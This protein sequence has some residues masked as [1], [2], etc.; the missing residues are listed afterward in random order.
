MQ[1]QWTPTSWQDKTAQ[2]QANYPDR[3]KLDKVVSELSELPPLV[4]S[5]EIDRLRTEIAEAQEGKRFILQGGDCAESL[6]ECNSDKIAKQLKILLQMNLILRYGM[7]IP[8]T[9]IGRLAGQYAKPRSAD[10]ETRDGITLPSYRGDLINQ[11]PFTE[12]ARIP[13]PKFLLK[14]YQYAGLTINFVRS[15]IDGGFSE[16][17]HADDWDLDFAEHSPQAEEFHNIVK[18]ILDSIG[19]FETF[20]HESGQRGRNQTIYTSH[21]GLH[22]HYEQAQTRFLP[23]RNDWYNLSTHLP[24]IGARTA[25]VEHAHV[26]YFSGIR[27]PIG[28]KVGPAM[29]RD[30]LDALIDKLNP[31]NEAGRLVLIHR[32]GADKIE[33]H[34][35]KLINIV[36][37]KQAKVLW[38]CDPMHGNT[39]TTDQ[40][41]K[42]RHFDNIAKEVELAFK[43]HKENGSRLG[44]VHFELTGENVTE[45]IGGARGLSAA[46]LARAYKTQVDPRLNYEQ[47]LELALG[48][49]KK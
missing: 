8:V 19:L 39:E 35:P 16:I 46:D 47:A 14:G 13:N 29:T 26:E 22:L 27:N 48:I 45:C 41:V 31:N 5:G 43:V 32:F 4:T 23:K 44:G 38:M 2:Q 7:K 33:E 12:K 18:T 10:T 30:W 34:L 17:R 15:L 28:V 20:N 25:D 40:G 6:S 49:I 9:V 3:E 37:A 11:S 24:W 21:E 42:T 1:K 36:H